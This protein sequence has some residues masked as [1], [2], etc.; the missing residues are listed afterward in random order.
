[1]NLDIPLTFK[2]L[3]FNVDG[4][5]KLLIYDNKVFDDA[6]KLLI[7]NMEFV[8]KLFTLLNIVVVDTFK[9]LLGSGCGMWRR[10]AAKG[11][12]RAA[13]RLSCG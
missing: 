7:A 11:R 13:P 2:S 5:V 1:M 12:W 9:L 3:T 6:F 8:D 10:G 4:L